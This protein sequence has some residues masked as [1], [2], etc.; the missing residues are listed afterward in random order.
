MFGERKSKMYAIQAVGF[1]LALALGAVFNFLSMHRMKGD[2]ISY[3]DLADSYLRLDFQSI[4]NSTWSPLY[5]AV[6]AFFKL[7]L[8]PD[9][10]Y[11]FAFVQFVNFLIYVG[12]VI[13]YHCLFSV[14]SVSAKSKNKAV[15][16]SGYVLGL[17]IFLYSSLSLIGS[18][19]VTPDMLLFF[20][21]L[22]WASA[23]LAYLT[24]RNPAFLFSIG[25]LLGIGFL[26]KA[27]LFILSIVSIASLSIWIYRRDG[28]RRAL[29][30]LA[31]LFMVIVPWIT[32]LSYQ[33]GR[34]T[35]SDIG[36]IN[37]C[38]DTGECDNSR[39]HYLIPL[40]DG[41]FVMKYDTAFSDATY[42]PWFDISEGWKEAKLEF[43]V[44]R[45][46]EIIAKNVSH[47]FS[48]LFTLFTYAFFAASFLFIVLRRPWSYFGIRRTWLIW[49]MSL[50]GGIYIM[51]HVEERYLGPFIFFVPL[52]YSYLDG[53]SRRK[54]LI[55]RIVLLITSVGLLLGVL[56][57]LKASNKMKYESDRNFL[58]G[59]NASAVGLKKGDRVVAEGD[60]I[61]M[62]WARLSGV[63][64]VG[65][66]AKTASFNSMSNEERQEMLCEM[67]SHNIRAFV[68]SIA[69]VG[70]ISGCYEILPGRA[71]VIFP[72]SCKRTDDLT[73]R[74]K[75]TEELTP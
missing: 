26:T 22:L 11:E 41:S 34:P 43:S 59:V 51:S 9:Q 27:V 23:C 54:D 12:A 66:L 57:P 49:S 19:G 21:L 55:L 1:S 37:Y 58:S 28:G 74:G 40:S 64:I 67:N 46:G 5:P 44:G 60:A 36:W 33:K 61:D 45:Q 38:L 7:I 63:R 70:V 65:E 53:H 56:Y 10:H 18:N 24:N 69:P 30:P 4:A 6:L 39:S 68:T 17:M 25:V 72:S 31:G 2:G 42:P 16:R 14:L 48:S 8:D 15:H 62:Y 73:N 3:L 29:L 35:F 71:Y 32:F 52:L 20:V 50:L 13:A 75:L 47:A